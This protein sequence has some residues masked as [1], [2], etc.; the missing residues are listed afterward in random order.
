VATGGS[1]A[2]VVGSRSHRTDRKHRPQ[3]AALCRSRAESAAIRGPVP[4]TN[5]QR[6]IKRP[7][8]RPGDQAPDLHFLV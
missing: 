4:P 1:V 2:T 3:G 6:M 7:D 5:H 8:R